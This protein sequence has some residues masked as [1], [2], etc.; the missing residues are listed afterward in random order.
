M[1]TPVKEYLRGQFLLHFISKYIVKVNNVYIETCISLSKPPHLVTGLDGK[2][3]LGSKLRKTINNA[4]I[5]V[6]LYLNN[7]VFE[8][9]IL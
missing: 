7:M 1:N 2:E 8:K 9:F 4:S 6:N 3:E 5:T